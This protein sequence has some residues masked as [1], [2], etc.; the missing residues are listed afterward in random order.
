MAIKIKKVSIVIPTYNRSYIIFECLKSIKS[1]NVK[2]KI[3][4]IIVDDGNDSTSDIVN[5]FSLINSSITIIYIKNT[6]RLGLPKSRNLGLSISKGELVIPFDSD[7][8]F[9]SNG[10][11]NIINAFEEGGD[12]DIGFFKSE[13]KSGAS[14]YNKKNING[15]LNYEIYI[16]NL[17]LGEYLPVLTRKFIERGFNYEENV[18]GFEGLLW[19]RALKSG[20]TLCV[21]NTVVQIYDDVLEGRLS[22]LN[23]WQAENRVN[24]LK[25]YLSEFAED[26]KEMNAPY[27]R[28]LIENYYVYYKIS[29]IDDL[30]IEL[31][32]RNRMQYLPKIFATLL[33]MTPNNFI[34]LVFPLLLMLRNIR[35]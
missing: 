15:L 3:E 27:Y 13:F 23:K 24:G 33:L 8:L 21:F 11:E 22:G 31:D 18:W 2:C 12:V 26:I 6:K 28:R 30:E 7:N 1:Q 19:G 20:C 29:N 25:I 4:I 10:I 35:R 9:L 17:P 16:S 32:L 14:N 34:S 5:D